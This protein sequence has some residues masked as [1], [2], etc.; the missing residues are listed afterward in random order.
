[1]TLKLLKTIGSF[2]VAAALALL[3]AGC[4]GEDGRDGRDGTDGQPG[5][6]GE[7]GT[8]QPPPPGTAINAKAMTSAQWADLRLQ[9][10]ITDVTM[11][12]PGAIPVVKFKLADANGTPV[13]GMTWTS[14]ATG[15]AYQYSYPN[16]AF[17]IAKLIPEK[18]ENNRMVA[19]SRWVNYI[20]TT[21]A[22][23]APAWNPG[24]PAT[25]NIGELKD[26]GDGTYEYTFFRDIK[27]VHDQLKNA[28]YSGSNAIEDLAGLPVT[29]EDGAVTYPDIAYDATKIHR[30]TIQVAGAYRGTGN[31]STRDANT[32]DGRD[33][34]YPA[35]NMVGPA[36]LIYDFIPETGAKVAPDAPGQRELVTTSACNDCH[37]K[38]GH[39]FHNGARWDV[40]YCT[41]CHTDQR[42]YGYAAS[43]AANNAFPAGDTRKIS[44]GS[45]AN[46]RTYAIGS[47]VYIGH[48]LHMGEKLTVKGYS[49]A[50]ISY[51]EIAYPM[52]VRN[53]TQCHQ[54]EYRYRSGEKAGEK[55][56]ETAAQGDNWFNKPGGLACGACHDRR[57]AGHIYRAD[58]TTCFGCHGNEEDVTSS[59]SVHPIKATHRVGDI[60]TLN[61]KTPA[62]LTNFEYHLESVTLNAARNPVIKF[63]ININGAPIISK[64]MLTAPPAGFD[65]GP[66]V[67][68]TYSR[69]QDGIGKPA[70]FTAS[71]NIAIS[72]L[73]A[74]LPDVSPN[75]DGT[76]EAT[77]T[78]ITVPADASIITAFIT[79]AYTQ[80]DP[81]ATYDNGFLGYRVTAS[82]RIDNIANSGARRAIT[83]AD[84]CNDCHDLYGSSVP[85]RAYSAH[86]GSAANDPSLC[87]MC[88]QARNGNGWS[89]N[90]I[91]LAHGIHA[92]GKRVNAYKRYYGPNNYGRPDDGNGNWK[93]MGA[94]GYPGVLNNCEQCHLPGTYDFSSVQSQAAL[95]NLL[96]SI[97]ASG[98]VADNDYK[99]PHIPAGSYSGADNN[100]LNSPITNA[101]SGCHDSDAAIEHMRANGGYFYAK[102]GDIV[103]EGGALPNKEGCLFCHGTGKMADIKKV[104]SRF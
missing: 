69:P 92:P 90:M 98:T 55:S 32:E 3:L 8:P 2:S 93:K 102:R 34:G 94:A 5:E 1:M 57:M 87:S 76:W 86:G 74:G 26:N 9:G 50:G 85:L 91:N 96:W 20:V 61:K 63:R 64:D 81:G 18:I 44:R 54:T 79:R 43:T 39:S 58:D 99:S 46:A 35:I 11:K 31:T 40:R 38:L 84:K 24:R 88:H 28:S 78:T 6:P 68:I 47:M 16:V 83:S 41:M 17:S 23:A 19:P 33:S 30:L 95:P 52:D 53:C 103:K 104:H 101:C 22:G 51:N 7:P 15:A 73:A 56:G 72:A 80:T 70:D 82:K 75:E 66:S 100:R 4:R 45:G 36:N 60:T 42:K 25:D 71:A 89:S 12:G 49:Y 48:T 21:P 13:A 27:E 10:E 29:L 65:N 37:G 14:R 59:S 97:T 77:A 67:Y 62:G